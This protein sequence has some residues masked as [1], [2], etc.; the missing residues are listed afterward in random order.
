MPAVQV[1]RFETRSADSPDETRTP[2]NSLVQQVTVGGH[3][4]ARMT[5]KPGWKWSENI[6]PIVGTDRC[7]LSHVGYALQ[8]SITVQT[9]EGGEGVIRAGDFYS[10]APGHDAWNEGPEDFVGLEI[11]SAAEYARG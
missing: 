6:R 11:V 5:F 4:L 2:P 1:D 8:G 10:I 3:T 7:Q 9:A